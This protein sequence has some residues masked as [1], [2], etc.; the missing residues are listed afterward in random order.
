MK[1]PRVRKEKVKVIGEVVVIIDVIITVF[2]TRGEEKG[3]RKRD[4]PKLGR[5]GQ[6]GN[7]RGGVYQLGAVNAHEDPKV[8]T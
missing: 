2:K 1:Q 3:H 5:N 6:G 4:C 7:N 8:V